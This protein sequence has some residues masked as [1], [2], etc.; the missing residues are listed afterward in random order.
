[1]NS[2]TF[3]VL[4]EAFT[5]LTLP[6][7]LTVRR[8]SQRWKDEAANTVAIF[9]DF[10]GDEFAASREGLASRVLL[11]ARG[12]GGRAAASSLSVQRKALRIAVTHFGHAMSGLQLGPV[13]DELVTESIERCQAVQYLRVQKLGSA[14][15][16]VAA[17]SRSSYRGTLCSLEVEGCPSL[18]PQI[19]ARLGEGFTSLETLVI[20]S[21]G[22]VSVPTFRDVIDALAPTLTSLTVSGGASLSEEHLMLLGRLPKLQ[23]LAL[24]AAA[25][26]SMVRCFVASQ[27]KPL[28]GLNTI[29][30]AAVLEHLTLS[31]FRS[32]SAKDVAEIC[33]LLQTA[34]V[35]QLTLRDIGWS[36]GISGLQLERAKSLQR[37]V[38]TG[39]TPNIECP[40]HVR[41][42]RF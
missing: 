26:G 39:S 24:D 4:Q 1:M 30:S 21:L 42:V 33:Q 10:C 32:L 5:W 41:I 6:E 14:D 7:L 2:V 22:P 23:S 11:E 28:Q 34:P 38:L 19:F 20:G 35:R 31:G 13:G 18:S 15:S 17:V 16:A 29:A 40:E 27:S 3:D 37:L 25:I 8:V 36:T 9:N 12:R